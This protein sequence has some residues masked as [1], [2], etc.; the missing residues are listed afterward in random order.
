MSGLRLEDIGFYTLSDERALNSSEKTPL[1][2]CELILTGRCNFKCPYC[3]GLRPDFRGEMTVREAELCVEEWIRM[4]LQNVRFSGGEPTLHEGLLPLVGMCQRANVKHIAV[5]T[6]GSADIEFYKLL[7]KH[8][9]NDFSISLDS[10][11]CSIGEK[12]TGGVKGAWEKVVTNIQEISKFCYVTVGVVFTEENVPQAIETIKFADSLGV[13]DIR[14][15]SSAQ[16]NQGI[17]ALSDVPQE[18][19]DRHPFL[20]YRVEN[21]RKDIPIRGIG[22]R[23][24]HKC[25]MVLDDMAVMGNYHF[26]CIIYM[27]EG[28]DPI[29]KV[30][31]GM[32]E[33]RKAWYNT[34]DSSQ[35]PICSKN[36]LDVCVAFNNKAGRN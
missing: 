33:E 31:P 24:C 17:R 25:K 23:D 32:R 36:C 20:K 26:P 7:H 13:R 4:G 28:G 27:R 21:F 29:G 30:G 34:H 19:L 12:M 8:G 15:I 9:V 2:R 5:S 10:G 11:C 22:P 14:V 18:I 3:R 16:F 1:Q 35:D 6:N